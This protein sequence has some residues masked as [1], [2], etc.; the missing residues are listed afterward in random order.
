VTCPSGASVAFVLPLHPGDYVKYPK[1]R[2]FVRRVSFAAQ[3][4]ESV[5]QCLAILLEGLT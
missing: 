5:V 3:P 1:R 4:E 2:E